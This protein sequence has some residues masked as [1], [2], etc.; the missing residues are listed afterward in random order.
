M[1]SFLLAASHSRAASAGRIRA[2]CLAFHAS[3]AARAREGDLRQQGLKRYY[4]KDYKRTLR[5]PA[6][7]GEG[8]EGRRA[9]ELVFSGIIE[10]LGTVKT[11]K[12]LDQG[13]RV[14]IRCHLPIAQVG[15]G[16]SI[17]VNGACL[18][19]VA[20]GA[21]TIAMDIS[22]ET[23]RR[24]TLGTLRVGERVNLERSLTM[25]SLLNGHLVSGHIDG[26]GRVVSIVSEGD[27]R[28]FTFEVA[29]AQARYLVEKGSVALD[30]VSLTVFDLRGRRFS[31]ALIPHTLAVT[32]LGQ[33]SASDRV[34]VESDLIAKYVE[35]LA[36][37]AAQRTAG[38]KPPM[39]Q[40]WLAS[41]AGVQP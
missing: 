16:D 27:S 32:T 8:S 3:A 11:L 37:S 31:C 23:L 33:K 18:T 28:L 39:A 10:D 20:K 40:A 9:R 2:E 12:R 26:V 35:R 36:A 17:A 38:R 13:L 1:P 24:T 6:S 34:N 41:S 15:I 21:A 19:V 29:P 22:A 4:L 25:A 5:P 7:R 30:G 14:T